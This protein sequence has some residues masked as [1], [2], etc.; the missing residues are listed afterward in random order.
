MQTPTV[1]KYEMKTISP[2]QFDTIYQ[3]IPTEEM[4]LL[5]E[6]CIETGMRVDDRGITWRSTPGRTSAQRTGSHPCTGWSAGCRRSAVA[7]NTEI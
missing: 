1:P 3:A 6:M 4:C 5:V 7:V 2:E